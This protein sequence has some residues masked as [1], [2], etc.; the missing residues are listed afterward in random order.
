MRHVDP[1]PCT[2][3][4]IYG[5]VGIPQTLFSGRPEGLQKGGAISAC[6]IY[7]STLCMIAIRN[8][9]FQIVILSWLYTLEAFSKGKLS[10]DINRYNW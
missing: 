3:T 2:C 4:Y 10:G 1:G 8:E 5:H 9:L 6:S 7:K